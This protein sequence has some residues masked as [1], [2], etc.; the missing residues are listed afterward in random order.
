MDVLVVSD[1][2]GT[3]HSITSLKLWNLFISSHSVGLGSNSLSLYYSIYLI[4][5]MILC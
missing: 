2:T 5:I 1:D 4:Y 3:S